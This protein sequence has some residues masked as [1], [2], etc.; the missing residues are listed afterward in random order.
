MIIWY[1][2]CSFGTFFQFWYHTLKNLATLITIGMRPF[3]RVPQNRT[4]PQ[5]WRCSLALLALVR[6]VLALMFYDYH[7]LPWPDSASWFKSCSRR[8][9]PN[10]PPGRVLALFSRSSTTGIRRTYDDVPNHKRIDLREE[11]GFR[12]NHRLLWIG[13]QGSRHRCLRPDLFCISAGAQRKKRQENCAKFLSLPHPLLLA[14]FCICSFVCRAPR[15]SHRGARARSRNP[16][17]GW[18]TRSKPS[19]F[20][21]QMLDSKPRY[22][23]LQMLVSKPRYFKLQK[24][25]VRIRFY[26]NL[27]TKPNLG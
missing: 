8:C 24:L 23:K 15:C 26:I 4:V 3:K 21:L 16:R 9:D 12:R 7:P 19:Y 20:K 1:I 5:L 18:P 25:S 17:P 2:L 10:T 22:F 27:H 14:G 11:N 6:L 13:W